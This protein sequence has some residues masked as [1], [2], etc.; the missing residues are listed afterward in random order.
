MDVRCFGGSAGE[1][2]HFFFG[3]DSW[4]SGLTWV[5]RFARAGRARGRCGGN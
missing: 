5:K 1:L 2:A 3:Q 4:E